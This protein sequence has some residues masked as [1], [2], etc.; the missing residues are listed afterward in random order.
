MLTTPLTQDTLRQ[1]V[2]DIFIYQMPFN[3]ELG[4]TLEA[5]SP[6]AV[7][8]SF[9]HQNKLVGNAL[10]QIL[11]GGVI[12]AGLDVAAGLV[13]VGSAL[14]RHDTLSE[15]ELHQRLS[16][17]GTIDLRVDYLR[18]GRGEHFILTSQLLRGGNKIAVARAELHNE[19]QSHI[20]SAI[21]TYIVG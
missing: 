10:Q 12:A 6:D 18:P 5:F 16:R 14:L 3:Q 19:K 2:S 9:H 4:L 1:R 13:C 8:L 15:Q 17:M 7:T 20:A 21:A 11:H